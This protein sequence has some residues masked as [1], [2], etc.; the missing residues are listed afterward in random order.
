MEAGI[1]VHLAQKRLGLCRYSRRKDKT[2]T[3]IQR[4]H[5]YTLTSILTVILII[6]AGILSPNS[7]LRTMVEW[8]LIVIV[9]F[10]AILIV[11]MF[12]SIIKEAYMLIHDFFVRH[13]ED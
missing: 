6:I 12:V 8:I 4:A 9:A 5:V 11:A 10:L 1:Y 7:F 3:K 2:M 13:I